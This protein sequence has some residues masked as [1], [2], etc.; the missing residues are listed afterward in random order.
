[1]G[2][3]FIEKPGSRGPWIAEKMCYPQSSVQPT[4]IIPP[5]ANIAS[6]P[7]GLAHY[8]G[9]GLPDRYA[10][11]FFLVDFTG[12]KGSGVHSFALKP[13]GAGYE[14]VDRDHLVSEVL[15]TDVE[16]G[17]DGG[18]YVSDWVQGWN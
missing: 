1:I 14:L 6:G 9:T 8:P 17:P 13:K 18:V 15:A 7:A 16:I 3:Q 11:H 12:G 5:I 10:G 2:F 4:Y